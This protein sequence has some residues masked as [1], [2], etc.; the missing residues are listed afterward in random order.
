MDLLCRASQ[1]V[2]DFEEIQEFE[3][4]PVFIPY[5]KKEFY[6]VDGRMRLFPAQ[7]KRTK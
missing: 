6:A 2:E 5:R 7:E 1:L 3:I 4:N